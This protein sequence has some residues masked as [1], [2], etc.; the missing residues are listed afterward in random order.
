MAQCIQKNSIESAGFAEDCCKKYHVMKHDVDGN[1]FRREWEYRRER[2]ANLEQYDEI[3][4]DYQQ[5]RS[6]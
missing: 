1:L 2:L 3:L 6:N 5:V 4:R